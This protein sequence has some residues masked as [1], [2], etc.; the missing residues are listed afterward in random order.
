MKKLIRR[1]N[2]LAHAVT[3]GRGAI[4]REFTMRVPVEH[5]RDADMV[6]SRAAREL[7]FMLIQFECIL[8]EHEVEGRLSHDTIATIRGILKESEDG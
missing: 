1:L 2:E 3:Q 8:V 5:D 6:L 7:S 4:D